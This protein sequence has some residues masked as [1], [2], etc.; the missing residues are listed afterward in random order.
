M[1][2]YVIRRLLM[3]IPVFF[4]TTFL[5]FLMVYAVPGDPIKALGGDR[6]LP[7]SVVAEYRERYNLNDPLPVQYAKYVNG[8]FHGDFGETFNGQQ[9]SEIMKR[10]FPVT[11]RLTLFAFLFELVIGLIAGVLAG[12]RR[13]SFMDS[14]VLVSTTA[15]VAVPVFV[16]GSAAQ[17]L[18]GLR[19]GWFPIAGIQ[20]GYQS[21]LLPGFVLAAL[22]L[23]Y[24]ARLTRTSLV[25]ASR[26]DYVRTAK[27]KGLPPRLV[28]GRHTLR[29]S[30]IPVVTYIGIDVGTLMGG[31]IVTEGIF[32]LPGVGSAVFTATVTKEGP[33]VVGV[34]TALVLVF[35]VANLLVDL[36]YAV[37]DPRIRY[38]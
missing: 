35:I 10:R 18:F 6:P 33:V 29:N 30:L 3:V 32:N 37:L 25:E 8:L 28:V 27:A 4:G 7:P 34:V 23:A 24:V 5:I 2:R 26:S 36:L 20:H 13:K 38:E 16:L 12:L 15:I 1:G 19:F 31:A 22:S 14:L 17:L 21:Y 11:I 9:V